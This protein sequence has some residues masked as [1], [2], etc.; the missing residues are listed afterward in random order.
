MSYA[1]FLLARK[2][3]KMKD[4]EAALKL[5]ADE[6]P[7]AREQREAQYVSEYL[8]RLNAALTRDGKDAVYDEF[9]ELM[10]EM[11]DATPLGDRV[12]LFLRVERLLDG[13]PDLAGEFLV[14]L[15]E[16]AAFALN[17]HEEYSYVTSAREFLRCVELHFSGQPHHVQKIGKVLGQIATGREDDI[18]KENVKQAVLPLLKGNSYLIDLFTSLL[19]CEPPPDR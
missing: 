7:E 6:D 8:L 15:G 5:L 14:F 17:R 13:Y 12:N 11:D 2:T 1:C 10:G 16:D 19:P 9:F 18:T 4:A 3:K